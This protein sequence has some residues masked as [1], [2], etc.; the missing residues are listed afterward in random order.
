MAKLTFW[1]W[2]VV[3]IVGCMF[4]PLVAFLFAVT[5]ALGFAALVDG[6]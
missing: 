4:G 3:L 2:V 6:K 5:V 1:F